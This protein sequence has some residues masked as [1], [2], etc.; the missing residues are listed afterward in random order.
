[1]KPGAAGG[2]DDRGEYGTG[3]GRRGAA[4]CSFVVGACLAQGS[5]AARALVIAVVWSLARLALAA[6]SLALVNR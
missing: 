4:C 2:E 6:R 5:L 1:L 3:E